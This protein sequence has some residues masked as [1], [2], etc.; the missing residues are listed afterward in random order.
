M[1]NLSL[2]SID[3]GHF[4]KQPVELLIEKKKKREKWEN[5]YAIKE[6]VRQNKRPKFKKDTYI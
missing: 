3:S 4:C 6:A 1:Q 2:S 5:N